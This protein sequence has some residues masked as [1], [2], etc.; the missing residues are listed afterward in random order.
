MVG[1]QARHCMVQCMVANEAVLAIRYLGAPGTGPVGAGRLAGPATEWRRGW[2]PGSHWTPPSSRC[3]A[4]KQ[5]DLSSQQKWGD[6]ARWQMTGQTSTPERHA[7]STKQHMHQLHGRTTA[8]ALTRAHWAGQQEASSY[9][10]QPWPTP[11]QH[12]DLP[13]LG[14]FSVDAGVDGGAGPWHRLCRVLLRLRGPLSNLDK[15]AVLRQ[16]EVAAAQ[17][18]SAEC[19]ACLQ[20][21]VCRR[22]CASNACSCLTGI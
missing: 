17:S 2:L 14:V 10:I 13:V 3:T 1:R 15:A 5:V 16:R 7:S 19:G 22:G 20:L 8:A 21:A 18:V 9:T 11:L 4:G 6:T 12:M